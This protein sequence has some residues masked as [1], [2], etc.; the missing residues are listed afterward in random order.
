M[1]TSE[2]EGNC[3]ATWTPKATGRKQTGVGHSVDSRSLLNGRGLS[4]CLF[5]LL[6]VSFCMFLSHS[7][8]SSFLLL[9]EEEHS[10]EVYPFPSFFGCF[11]VCFSV[12]FSLSLLL[13]EEGAGPG[14][15]REERLQ[16]EVSHSVDSRSLLNGRGL[17]WCLFLLLSVSFYVFSGIFCIF[18]VFSSERRKA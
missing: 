1:N 6:S 18:I 12:C 14:A 17:S 2:E 7:V 4:W 13:L 16:T 8:S 15:S 11:S 9:G 3:N 10:V 5:V